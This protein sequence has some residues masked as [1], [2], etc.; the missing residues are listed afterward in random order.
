MANKTSTI[1][2]RLE[3]LEK[4]FQKLKIETFFALPKKKLKFIYPEKSLK[5]AIRATRKAIWQ[6][7]YAK[8]V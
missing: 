2:K 3:R 8:K 7:R 4:D 6:E 1:F 5:E